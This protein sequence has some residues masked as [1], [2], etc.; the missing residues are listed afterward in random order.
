MKWEGGD[1]GPAWEGVAATAATALTVALLV[2]TI[3][4][5]FPLLYDVREDAGAGTAVAWA[6][7]AFVLAPAVLAARLRPIGRIGILIAVVGLAASRAAEQFL[8]PIPVWLGAAGVAIGLTA[9]LLQLLEARSRD[10]GAMAGVTV[11]AG[12]ALDTALLGA[13]ETWDAVWQDRKKLFAL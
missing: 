3:R 10:E 5:A 11:V 1:P 2:Q 4:V 13:F 12:L 6:M 8:H 7:G 9:L